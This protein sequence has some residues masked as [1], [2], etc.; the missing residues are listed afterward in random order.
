MRSVRIGAGQGFYGDSLLPV[1]DVARYGNVKYIAFDTLA[2]L[3]LAI[4][5]KG[6][7]KDPDAGYTRDVVPMMRNLLPICYERGIKL[8][9]NAGGMNPPGAARAVAQVAREL[10]I[11]IRI[12]TVTGDNIVD[13]LDELAEKGY[14]FEN[15]ETGEALGDIRERVLFASVYLG[16]R[17]IAEALARGADV[18]ITGRTTDTAQFLGPVLHEFGWAPDDWDRLAQGIVLGHLM[19][20]SGQVTGGNFTGWR[21]VPD[22]WR[23]GFP[24]AEVYEDGSFI[25]TK[26][27]GTGGAVTEATVKEQFLYEIHDPREYITPDV[28]CDLTTTRIEQVGPDRVRVWGTRGRPAPHTL[29]ALLG[30]SDGWAG[31]GYVSFSWPDAL[32]KARAAEEIVRRRLEMQGV[33]PEEI[34]VEYIGYNSLW[35]ALAPEPQGELNEVR[36]RIAIRCRDREDCEKLSREFPP[37]YLS[38]PMNAAAIH[39]TPAPRELMGLWSTLI[40]RE[41]IEPYIRIDVTEVQVEGAP[42]RPAPAAAAPAADRPP[43]GRPGAGA[44]DRPPWPAGKPV[45]TKGRV[46]LID[47]AH[48]RAGDKGDASDIS[49]FAYNEEAWQILREHVTAE[50]VAEYFRPIATGPVERYE[51]PNVRALKFIVHGALGGGAPRSLRSDNLGKTMA[52]ALLRMELD[53]P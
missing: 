8:I 3:T 29:K 44:P 4:L 27:E 52:A 23:I 30:Y 39:G 2:E 46:R 50:R 38:G 34:H 9:T 19:E 32:D 16:A 31:E 47:L 26:P 21:E 18:V 15:K 53:L 37:L 45:P 48:G 5:Q 7:K 35:G 28:I 13:R 6:R 24:V 22:L 33:R 43:A 25:L 36:L 40:P 1:L 49:L 42:P 14:R 11:P 20:C 51:V 17:P 10:G 41:E 12:A